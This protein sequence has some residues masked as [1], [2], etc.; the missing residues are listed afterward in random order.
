MNFQNILFLDLETV[1]QYASY[2]Q[3]PE[4]WQHAWDE[5]SSKRYPNEQPRDTYKNAG[6]YPEFGKI[7]CISIGVIRFIDKGPEEGI[8]IKSIYGDEKEILQTV[9]NNYLNKKEGLFL[10]AH[11]GK[12]FDYPYL[13]KRFIINGLKLPAVLDISDKKPWEI[14]HLDT[15]EMW[16]FGDF[17][18][19]TS[20]KL[21]AQALGMPS[22]KDDI[23]GS[24]VGDVY[25]VEK[26]P[27]RIAE[28]CE[29]DVKTLILVF[30]RIKSAPIIEHI[31][32]CTPVVLL[33]VHAHAA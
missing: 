32:L 31:T 4:D 30:L 19:F 33:A 28:Y 3:L 13:C 25:W 8:F 5:L 14:K 18:N 9:A 1:P 26:N 17:K 27:A 20:L 7:A 29:K 2:D 23:D 6:I 21:I 12:G 10:C 15:M 24:M 16:R 11:N 22:P